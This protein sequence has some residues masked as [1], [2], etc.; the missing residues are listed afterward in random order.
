MITSDMVFGYASR[1][2]ARSEKAGQGTQWPT[3][4]Q[5]AK[6]FNCKISDVVD[7][8]ESYIGSAVFCIS[9]WNVNYEVPRGEYLVEAYF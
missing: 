8:V 6:R 3:L 2:A 9:Y 4:A 7:A 1:Y 5:C